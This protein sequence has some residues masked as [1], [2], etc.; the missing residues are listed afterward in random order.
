MNFTTPIQIAEFL[1]DI[2]KTLISIFGN[3]WSW[4]GTEFLVFFHFLGD[5]GKLLIL[6]ALN[7]VNLLD[8]HSGFVLVFIA[9]LAFVAFLIFM[10]KISV[11]IHKISNTISNRLKI[12]P[13]QK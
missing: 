1:E 2:G 11:E 10:I 4:L 9:F 3:I 13:W 6:I 12:F 8:Y 5:A 7:L